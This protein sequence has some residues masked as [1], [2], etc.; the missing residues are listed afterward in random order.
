MIFCCL[1][2][3]DLV[4]E[5]IIFNG[6]LNYNFRKNKIVYIVLTIQLHLMVGFWGNLYVEEKYKS[7]LIFFVVLFSLIILLQKITSVFFLMYIISYMIVCQF[8]SLINAFL[9]LF[10]NSNLNYILCSA[11]SVALTFL[12]VIICRKFNVVFTKNIQYPFIYIVFQIIVLIL[13]SSIIGIGGNILEASNSPF[14]DK[15][16]FLFLIITGII[17]SSFGFVLY[18]IVSA[19]KSHIQIEHLNRELLETEFKHYD[20]IRKIHEEAKKIRHDINSHII[21]LK[22][23]IHNNNITDALAYLDKIGGQLQKTETPF[24]IGNEVADAI[25]LEKMKNITNLQIEL[26]IQ[27]GFPKD[28]TIPNYDMC[29]IFSNALQNAIEACENIKPERRLITINIGTFNRYTTIVFEN[30]ILHPSNLKTS[31]NDF[32]NHGIGLLNIRRSVESLG[33]NMNITQIDH[34]F[35]LQL[36]IKN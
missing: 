10:H 8:D 6:V 28:S 7:I 35:T 3:A 19:N 31:K 30:P 13:S 33:G 25:I 4:K 15:L 11:I 17:V 16:F 21:C 14:Y 5:L 27:G 2:I 1:S 18:T 24:T 9:N 22:A 12:L 20:E 36:I 29:I 32:H 26:K 23:L 34:K